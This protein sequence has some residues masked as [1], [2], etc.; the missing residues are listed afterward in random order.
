MH[1]IHTEMRMCMDTKMETQ[2]Q[3]RLDKQYET[4]TE[5]PHEV[6]LGSGGQHGQVQVDRL[7]VERRVGNEVVINVSFH[8]ENFTHRQKNQ[9]A[10]EGSGHLPDHL[11]LRNTDVVCLSLVTELRADFVSQ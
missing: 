6:V 11:H 9:Q 4:P 5:R 10:E 1:L 8:G 3:E 7:S 2:K